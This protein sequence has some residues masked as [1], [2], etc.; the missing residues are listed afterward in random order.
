MN[1]DAAINPWRLNPI[2]AVVMRPHMEMSHKDGFFPSREMGGESETLVDST[3]EQEIDAIAN[4]P[5]CE[6]RWQILTN[7]FAFVIMEEKYFE[8]S[9]IKFIIKIREQYEFRSKY[10]TNV[11]LSAN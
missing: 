4:S 11:M 5:N 9:I 7:S 3:R 10:N 2:G 1:K 6:I 8:S